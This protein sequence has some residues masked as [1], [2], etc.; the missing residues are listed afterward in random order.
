MIILIDLDGI[1]VDLLPN[2]IKEY[3]NLSGDSLSIEMVND[4]SLGNVIKKENKKLLYQVFNK[5]GFF[6]TL[7]PIEGAL[8]TLKRLSKRHE[9]YVASAAEHPHVAAEKLHWIKNNMPFISL[10]KVFLG[11]DKYILRG[12]CFI[13]DRKLNL[14]NYRKSWPNAHILSIEYP[15]NKDAKQYCNLM[16]KDCKNTKQAWL[17]I[18]E[19]INNV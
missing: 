1:V 16:A 9:L 17:Q 12:D 14:E 15:F 18:E 4:W 8:E 11:H 13:D 7:P 3:N 2:W 10:K 19:Y 5:E 6:K